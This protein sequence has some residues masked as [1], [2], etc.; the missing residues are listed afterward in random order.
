VAAS[1]K[2]HHA[3]RKSRLCQAFSGPQ[4]P[5]SK[6]RSGRSRRTRA[7]AIAPSA[8]RPAPRQGDA[9]GGAGGEAG[10][11]DDVSMV[12][13]RYHRPVSASPP[14]PRPAL[15]AIFLGALLVRGLGVAD[16][17]RLPDAAALAEHL[18]GASGRKL[19]PFVGHEDLLLRA[20][21]GHPPDPS[22]QAWPTAIAISRGLGFLTDDPRALVGLAMVAGALCAVLA[23]VWTARHFGRT[24]GL[25]AGVLVA[26]LGEHAAW[27]TSTYPVIH[28]QA[29][30]LG[31]FVVRR[32]VP[33]ATLVAL[34]VSLR[35]ELAPLA[36]FRGWPGL[37]GLPV[38]A[39]LVLLLPGPAP[40]DPLLSL[41]ANLPMLRYIGPPILL[42]SLIGLRERRAWGLLGLT[43][44]GHVL[45]AT[46]ADLGARHELLGAVALCALGGVAAARTHHVVGVVLA[47]GL[48]WDTAAIRA[49]W[50]TP[51]A[52]EAASLELPPPD[53]RCLEVSGE[54]PIPGQ[55][56]PSHLAPV[57]AE[58]TARCRVWG[59][60]DQHAAWT[61]RGLRDR[62]LRIRTLYRLT[63][64][65]KQTLGSGRR[66]RV[67]HRLEDRW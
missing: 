23:A 8:A 47:V 58:D 49:A 34:A 19:P 33:A 66:V 16:L 3:P 59:E 6:V 44:L 67:Q 61:S 11:G 27:S 37:A 20:F 52:P 45:G 10:S 9:G 64:V 24:A 36:L 41:A 5:V 1:Q 42:L 54:P 17:S 14:L 18:S 51:S 4:N 53:G 50:H 25:W 21:A 35:P 39:A 30:L 40:S 65:A 56:I 2:S 62:A 7:T 26:L 46:F 12:R 28:A 55:P 38:A 43:A 32:R 63:P 31:A 48:A 60:E 22:A 15:A 13:E 57:A 29:L